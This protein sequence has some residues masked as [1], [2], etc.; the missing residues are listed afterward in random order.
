MEPWTFGF[1]GSG[2]AAMVITV[3]AA[4]VPTLS[5][6]QAASLHRQAHR[7]PYEPK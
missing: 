6:T 2:V 7:N 5:T 4:C 1:V 3:E